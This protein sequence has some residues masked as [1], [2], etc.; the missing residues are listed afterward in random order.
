MFQVFF[1]VAFDQ[2]VARDRQHDATG[3]MEWKI[4]AHFSGGVY[5]FKWFFAHAPNMMGNETCQA[6]IG[7]DE[8]TSVPLSDGDLVVIDHCK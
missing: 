5:L 7:Y 8:D 6:G 2:G 1:T 3:S 4:Y